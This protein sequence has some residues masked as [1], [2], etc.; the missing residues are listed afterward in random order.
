MN[1]TPTK[2]HNM[3]LHGLIKTMLVAAAVTAFAACGQDGSPL[4][5]GDQP[6]ISSETA[7]AP[8]GSA[9]T[10]ENA[11]SDS[12]SMTSQLLRQPNAAK[13]LGTRMMRDDDCYALC[14]E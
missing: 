1:A 6:T 10:T 3:R 13:R 5:P 8:A 14:I 11:T 9:V 4:G 7:N 2:G 12:S